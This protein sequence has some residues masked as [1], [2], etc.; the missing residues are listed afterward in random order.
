MDP[1]PVLLPWGYRCTF[2]HHEYDGTVVDE[3]GWGHTVAI[4]V[5]AVIVATGGTTLT[6]TRAGK[7]GEAART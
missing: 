5:G 2:T 1:E 6:R 4:G 7:T 3:P